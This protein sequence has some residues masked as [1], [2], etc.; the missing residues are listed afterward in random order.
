MLSEHLAYQGQLSAMNVL[1]TFTRVGINQP[2]APPLNQCIGRQSMSLV[3][4]AFSD[5]HFNVSSGV[6]RSLR[7]PPLAHG[8][9]T[10][11]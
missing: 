11:Q 2:I 9:G 8:A 5:V 10:C 3:T 1:S 4:Y 6:E 7:L